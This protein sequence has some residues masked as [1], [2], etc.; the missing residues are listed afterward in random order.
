MASEIAGLEPLRGF[1]KQENKV[2]PVKFAYVEKRTLQPAFIERKM[3]VREA[4]A[5][6]SAV[7]PELL[8]A[9]IPPPK[10][11]QALTT[12]AMSPEPTQPEPRKSAFKK[13]EEGTA[14]EWKPI[15]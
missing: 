13:K 12:E 15:D 8:A 3:T 14:R 11:I 4:R 5:L 6:P 2:V 7:V 1:I 10:E 9:V